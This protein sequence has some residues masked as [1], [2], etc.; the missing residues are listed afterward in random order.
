[1]PEM[2]RRNM[3]LMSGL[4]LLGAAMA[5]PEAWAQPAPPGVPG[6]PAPAPGMPVPPPAAPQQ[7]PLPGQPP[8][9]TV[10]GPLLFGDEFDGPAGAA[11]DRSKW[12]VQTWQDNV[13]PP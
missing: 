5:V 2:D 4:G 13:T 11:P 12:I 9:G 10:A 7:A 6:P 8:G 3:M 1:M